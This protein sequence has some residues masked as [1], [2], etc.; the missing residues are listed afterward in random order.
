MKAQA[1]APDTLSADRPRDS[2]IT[3][4]RRAFAGAVGGAVAFTRG[5]HPSAGTGDAGKRAKATNGA[6]GPSE[7][8][9][10]Y[11]LLHR[12]LALLSL[13]NPGTVKFTSGAIAGAVGKT[14]TAPFD[15]L[16]LLMQV[17]GG[18]QGGGIG[19][20]AARG[21]LL[22]SFVAIGKEEGLRGYWKG[23][24][25]QVA[26][27]L[28]YSA[29]QL[30]SYD[31][32]KGWAG[33]NSPEGLTIPKKLAAGACAGM[34]STL[35]TYPLDTIRLRMAVDPA[36]K[37]IPG[38]VRLIAKD[39]GVGGFYRGV[40]TALIGIAPYMALELC[41]FDTLPQQIPAFA[42]GFSAA[43]IATSVCYPMDTLRRQMQLTASG[44]IRAAFA[45]AVGKEGFRAL[46]RGFVPN[47]IKNLPNKG[48]RL[49]I[50]DAVKRATVASQAAYEDEQAKY[51]AE[52]ARKA[53]F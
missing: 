17:K 43:L 3:G 37:S 31:V 29:A 27:V 9:V 53:R 38:A 33:G 36:S 14:I 16:K 48:V 26:R 5:V 32:F 45:A 22:E 34:F 13:L 50:Y 41:A 24:F 42:R 51:S 10:D 6:A 2:S 40:G 19:A 21:G 1:P 20:A 12:P 52:Q 4:V 47:A 39:G 8:P 49:G 44:G 30:Y 46:Y 11:L 35:A 25:A 7:V 28:P 18:L 23:N 15:R